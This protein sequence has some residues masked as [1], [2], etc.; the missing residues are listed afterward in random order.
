MSFKAIR[1]ESDVA[2]WLASST[3]HNLLSML[4]DIAKASCGNPIEKTKKNSS[5]S[6]E[7]T[8]GPVEAVVAQLNN[9]SHLVS[10]HPPV[11]QPQRYGNTAF[12]G[13]LNA[14]EKE[15]SKSMASLLERVASF[16]AF[17][18]EH[19]TILI[20]E[21]STYWKISFGNSTRIDYGTGHEASFLMLLYC[22]GKLNILELDPTKVENHLSA[23]A[24]YIYPTYLSV[25]RLVQRTYMLEP[26]GSHGVWSLDD[27]CFL[28]FLLG[29]SQLIDHSNIRPRSILYDEIIE[30]YSSQYMYL[31][32]VNFI[33]TVK[34]GPFQEHS[35]IL[36]ELST[37]ISSWEDIFNGLMKMFRVE[38]LGKFPVAQHFYFGTILKPTWLTQKDRNGSAGTRTSKD[39][40]GTAATTATMTTAM[41][42]TTT[43][44][45]TA[46]SAFSSTSPQKH[47]KLRPKSSSRRMATSSRNVSG[48]VHVSKARRR[49]AKTKQDVSRVSQKITKTN[50]TTTKPG[51]TPGLVGTT[52]KKL[53]ITIRR[54]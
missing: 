24:L 29:A 20:N 30:G 42:E 41:G 26:A 17:S 15:A 23:V 21:L 9:I 3:C 11:K 40:K 16:K 44:P 25:A 49:K 50:Y 33:N 12:R 1:N 52:P 5:N 2:H 4:G 18:S 53:A 27:Y 32:A 54:K 36:Y 37:K 34:T 39:T 7:D 45:Q 35:H 51:T 22:L 10:L 6:S 47:R 8:R 28:P 31:G 19:Q 13:W 43:R 46:A 38:V 14:V 48:K